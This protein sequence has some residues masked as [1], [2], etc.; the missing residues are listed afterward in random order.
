VSTYKPEPPLDLEP[1]L[2]SHS[3]APVNLD[4]Y[5]DAPAELPTVGLGFTYP[6][7]VH[8]RSGEPESAKTLSAYLDCIEEIRRGNAVMVCDFEMGPRRARAWFRDCG[9]DDCEQVI[10]LEPQEPLRGGAILADL[11]YLLDDRR[12]TLVVIDSYTAALEL[13]GCDPN[14]AVDVQRFHREVIGPLRAGRAA[15]VLTDHLPKNREGRGRFSIASE[16]KLANA[17]V[18]LGFEVVHPFGHGR[19]ALIRITT[20]KDRPASLP[21]PHT[22]ELHL[23]SDPETYAISWSIEHSERRE[24]GDGWKPTE[25]MAKV[26]RHLKE[27]GE[28]LS[29]T[30]IAREV[31][32]SKEYVLRAVDE[33]VSEGSIEE[34]PGSRGA[35]LYSISDPSN[36]SPTGSQTGAESHPSDPSTPLQGGDGS[37]TGS[38]GRVEPDFGGADDDIPF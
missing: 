31:G 5:A 15:I 38:L 22:C 3:W 20:H 1:P 8:I 21:K 30:T 23:K 19:E 35:R 24:A 29:R 26:F 34:N 36:P 28:P 10:F 18:H 4:D 12:P 2:R 6:G 25:L 17:D 13:H 9:L 16:R 7:C 14:S 11:G 32:G 37:G 27:R 33:L